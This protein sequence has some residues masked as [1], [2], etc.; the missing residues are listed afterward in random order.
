MTALEDIPESVERNI[1][2]SH[3]GQSSSDTYDGTTAV[4]HNL[5]WPQPVWPVLNN[6]TNPETPPISQYSERV[7]SFGPLPPED[8]WAY[9]CA[10]IVH[11]LIWLRELPWS[12]ERIVNDFVPA[13]DGRGGFGKQRPANQWYKPKSKKEQFDNE[14]L[15]SSVSPPMVLVLPATPVSGLSNGPILPPFASN[16]PPVIPAPV[17]PSPFS[18]SAVT[19]I[20]PTHTPRSVTSAGLSYM[21]P[22]MSSHGQGRQELTYSWY[23]GPE[24]AQAWQSYFPQFRSPQANTQSQFGTDIYSSDG[25]YIDR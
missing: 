23:S 10:R 20:R 21:S 22:G 6:I 24:T 2:E 19:A 13:R 1:V 7:S 12:E 25:R 5:A 18:D 8:T 4:N 14:K 9:Y 11:F 16:G 15:A 3:R 17:I